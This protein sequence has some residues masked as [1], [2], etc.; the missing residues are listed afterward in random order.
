MPHLTSAAALHVARVLLYNYEFTLIPE[1][2][3]RCAKIPNL[4]ANERCIAIIVD[5]VTNVFEVAALR[6]ELKY[7]QYRLFSS[8]P[9]AHLAQ[10]VTMFLQRMIAAFE[11]VPQYA[12]E[13]K[14]LYAAFA[15]PEQFVEAAGVQQISRAAI[16]A[17]RAVM[18]YFTL[19]QIGG[20]STD[21]DRVATVV[22]AALEITRALRA[23]PVARQCLEGLQENRLTLSQVK[24]KFRAIG[25]WLEYLS[26]YED[27]N[28]ELKLLA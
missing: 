13:E 2:D 5:Y 8:T 4:E 18:Q 9:D 6:P 28:E 15:A 26:C 14:K 21:P 22:D 17:Q 27:R 23:L 3:L 20:F 12:Q 11:K 10:Q 16:Q 25:V 7:W 1:A 19:R 24:A